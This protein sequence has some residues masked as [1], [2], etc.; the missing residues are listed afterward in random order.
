MLLEEGV[1]AKLGAVKF[2]LRAGPEMGFLR[3]GLT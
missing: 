1:K 2:G 3:A